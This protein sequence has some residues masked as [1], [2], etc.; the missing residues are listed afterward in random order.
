[1][2]S[3]NGLKAGVLAS[4]CLVLMACGGSG[5][6]D[7]TPSNISTYLSGRVIDGYLARATVFVDT[8]NNGRRDAWEAYAYTDDEGYYSYNPNTNT[9]YC[10]A[11]I[12]PALSQYCLNL[13]VDIS[14]FVIRI[15]SGY[16]LQTGEPFF[17][18]LSR[19]VNIQENSDPNFIISPITT[20]V[21]A[22]DDEQSTLTLLNKLGLNETDMDVDYLSDREFNAELLSKAI[23]IH[24]AVSVIADR[25]TD[26]YD[27]IGSS[28]GTPNDASQAVYLNLAMQ[29]NSGT[30]TADEV[31][32]SADDLVE[33]MNEAEA[34]LRS[35]YEL[36]ELNLPTDIGSVNDTSGFSRA[37]NIARQ[38]PTI[39]DTVFGGDVDSLTRDDVD[40]KIK[41]IE[42]VVVKS[43]DEQGGQDSTIDSAIAFITA[44]G[45]ATLV[46]SLSGILNSGD[47]FV[48]ALKNNDFSGEDFDSPEDFDSAVSLPS[49]AEAFSLIA[50]KTVRLS[51]PDIGDG[52][53]DLKDIEVAF[54]F[55]G[56]SVADA[57]TFKACVKYIDGASSDGS[58]GDGNTRGELIEGFWTLLNA[59][60][61]E[62]YSILM[63]AT[64]LG[65][66]YQ[67]VIKPAGFIMVDGEER[68][69]LRFD[70]DGDI[71]DWHTENGF[72]FATTVPN[73][74]SECEQLL[75]SRVGI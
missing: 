51:D 12:D 34:R 57:G 59:Q 43:L 60:N 18:Q 5:Q 15:D 24:K 14:H 70:F 36:R 6:D 22:L 21:T 42:S 19:R 61:N 65:G 62:S 3:S 25:L 49:G 16:D 53:N 72:N 20:L 35:I 26:V 50:G 38:V 73:S 2:S 52:P 31:L 7:G 58:L 46:E 44:V 48:S 74:A 10:V 45:N 4:M 27:E 40:G 55:E 41:L 47:T 68:Y 13:Q 33:V 66:S 67:S 32:R 30:N 1:M 29:I 23:T 37:V 64:F 63:T 11:G 9:D 71:R 17:G 54:F 8:N 69:A 56:E 39:V 28:L 75:P